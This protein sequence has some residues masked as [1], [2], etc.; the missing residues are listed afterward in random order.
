MPLCFALLLREP[1]KKVVNRKDE[2]CSIAPSKENM[3][4]IEAIADSEV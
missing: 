1:F 2:E 3:D 4:D